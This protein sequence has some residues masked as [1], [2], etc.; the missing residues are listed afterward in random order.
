MGRTQA[1][2]TVITLPR[3]T[4]SRRVWTVAELRRYVAELDEA[5]APD[6]VLVKLGNSQI[7][8]EWE[9]AELRK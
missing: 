5:G 9:M 2:G 1:M 3:V 4:V 7:S 8:V 6:R